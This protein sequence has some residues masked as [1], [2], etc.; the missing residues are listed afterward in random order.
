MKPPPSSDRCGP[1]AATRIG[2]V[3]VASSADGASDN[4]CAQA[5]VLME[6]ATI[7]AGKME[8]CID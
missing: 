5:A 7:T 3:S 6:T 8:R 2:R 4:G 1:C